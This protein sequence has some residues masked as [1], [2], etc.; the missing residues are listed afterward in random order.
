MIFIVLDNYGKTLTKLGIPEGNI[1][2]WEQT[3]RGVEVAS[4]RT[5]EAFANYTAFRSSGGT[6]T[7]KF[8]TDLSN[9]TSEDVS[10]SLDDVSSDVKVWPITTSEH[11]IDIRSFIEK[12]LGGKPMLKGAG[13]YQLTKEEKKVQ[14]YKKILIKDKTTGSIYYG[15]GARQLLGLPSYGDAKVVPGDHGNF[16]I[17]VQSTSVNRKLAAGT[18]LVYFPTVGTRYKEGI[19]SR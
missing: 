7:T 14:D 18:E 19:S 2:E 1:L 12:K 3:T 13:F 10:G 15:S 8:Y 4:A 17:Y 16:A 11:E 9:V 6:S 5:R